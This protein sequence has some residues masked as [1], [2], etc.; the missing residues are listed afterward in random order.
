MTIISEQQILKLSKYF[1]IIHHTKGR[2]RIAVNSKIK[3]MQKELKTL[4]ISI[5]KA[6]D[7]PKKIDGIKE[8]KFIA[9]LGTITIIYDEN[10]FNI[11]MV[12]DFIN[13]QNI[14]QATD[15]I[16]T[17]INKFNLTGG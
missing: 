11:Q 17:F 14:K 16:N 6:K 12:E 13:G 7:I 15:F 1:S 9:L 4:N 8:F 2:M 10:I 5:D 3:E